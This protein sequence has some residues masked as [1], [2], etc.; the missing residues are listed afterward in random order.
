MPTM[1]PSTKAR[2][3]FLSVACAT[4]P[5]VLYY[6]LVRTAVFKETWFYVGWETFQAAALTTCSRAAPRLRHAPAERRRR[7]AARAADPRAQEAPDDGA[8]HASRARGPAPDPRALTSA[9]EGLAGS[10]SAVQ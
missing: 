4:G 8:P 1:S 6:L 10:S 7:R 2:L 9:G 3:A 5:S